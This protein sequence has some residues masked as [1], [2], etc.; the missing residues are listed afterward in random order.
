MK[1]AL[2][3]LATIAGIIALLCYV[4]SNTLEARNACQAKGGVYISE[5]GICIKAERI[6]VP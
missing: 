2:L 4:V 3:I 6:K 1:D 5:S